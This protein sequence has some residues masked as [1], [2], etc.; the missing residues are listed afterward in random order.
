MNSPG[1]GGST[2]A[3]CG[4]RPKRPGGTVTEYYENARIHE[5]WMTFHEEPR[6]RYGY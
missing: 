1:S 3:G 2:A 4:A 5:P 6:S